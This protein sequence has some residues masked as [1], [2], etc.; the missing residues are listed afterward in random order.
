MVTASHLSQDRNGL[1]FF[2]K[3]GGL[4]NR[5]IEIL[6]EKTCS[7]ARE[8]HDMGVAPPASR[9]DG[10]YCSS[11]VIIW[12]HT[13]PSS[14]VPFVAKSNL[15]PCLS[16]STSLEGLLP[17][18]ELRMVLNAGNGSGYF[19]NDILHGLGADVS[20]SIH[21]TPDGTFPEYCAMVDETK[22]TC[23]NCS[24]DHGIMLETDADRCGFILPRGREDEGDG[25]RRYEALNRNRLIALLAVMF[26]SC[27]PGCTFVTD[28]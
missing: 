13:N 10:V 16:E 26:Q 27:S 21:L 8:W 5:D 24:A 11:W 2:T 17:L 23:E 7:L 9:K 1:K 12:P 28:R 4:T 20:N 18:A 15:L 25:G 6:A 3:S 22:I 14:R 19:F